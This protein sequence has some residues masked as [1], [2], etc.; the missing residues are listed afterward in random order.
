MPPLHNRVAA[1]ITAYYPGKR[2]ASSAYDDRVCKRSRASETLLSMPALGRGSSV[3]IR[4][5]ETS[6]ATSYAKQRIR[7]RGFG[8]EKGAI[9]AIGEFAKLLTEIRDKI[10]RHLLIHHTDIRVLRGWSL[11]FPRSRPNL[12]A[13]LLNICRV[14]YREGVRILY[15]ENTF[16]YLIRDPSEASYDTGLIVRHVYDSD[17][18]PI[19]K[20]G[21]LIRNI[22]IIIEANR[23]RLFDSRRNLPT[24]IQKFLPDHGFV[25]AAQL[26][27]VTIEL[28]AI[29]RAVLKMRKD[30]GTS[31]ED[32]PAAQWFQAGSAVLTALRRLNCQFIRIVAR[33][34]D[35]E[36]YAALVDRRPHFSK[37]SADEGNHDAWASDCVMLDR[38][39]I[40]AAQS[41]SR[42]NA[43]Y[44][45]L[46]RLISQPSYAL[47]KGPFRYYVPEVKDEGP[48]EQL[49]SG[50]SY[51]SSGRASASRAAQRLSE[52]F[53][54]E[55]E[56]Q[57]EEMEPESSDD[58]M[59]EDDDDD[60]VDSLFVG[61]GRGRGAAKK[62]F[63]G[64]GIFERL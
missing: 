9:E 44:Y 61:S 52:R 47:E 16:V 56:D 8:A 31:V 34:H 28:P 43:M 5:Q 50:T 18:I 35:G 40:N 29:T 64:A 19:N 57:D 23:M 59:G 63:V 51:T 41:R 10:F 60:N 62:R 12:Q 55:S 1:L 46:E 24:A 7:G 42:L 53:L 22:K 3:N 4:G 45:W 27:T 15:G 14:F 13:G 49:P 6:R 21:H 38:R 39:H 48:L 37:L 20:Y 30:V 54:E 25:T 17:Q 33:T 26:H 36:C 2:R 11:L 58:G 32:I